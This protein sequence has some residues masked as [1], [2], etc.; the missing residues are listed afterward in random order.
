MS[1]TAYFSRGSSFGCTWVWNPGEDEP[2]NLLGTAI[3][4]TLRDRCDNEYEMA[5]VM[6]E[7]GLSFT[8]NYIG[9]T[10]DW[11]LGQSN[12]DIRFVFPGNPITSS[13]IFRVIVEDTVTTA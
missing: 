6:A 13:R 5:V 2:A 9:S 1:N 8:T 10:S 3:T 4:S 7:N 12:W 11:A